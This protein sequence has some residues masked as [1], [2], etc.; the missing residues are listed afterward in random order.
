MELKVTKAYQQSTGS[1]PSRERIFSLT[2][3]LVAAFI[4]GLLI[5]LGG[6]GV[7]FAPSLEESLLGGVIAAG[8]LVATV[9]LW[10]HH[11]YALHAWALL[12]SILSLASAL[13]RDPGPHRFLYRVG[14]YGTA[15][16]LLWSAYQ[17]FSIGN[18]LTVK[19]DGP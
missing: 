18:R 8:A 4:G 5:I 17:L 12:A 13:L 16:F 7:I 3:R 11:R 6:V 14:R 19:R 10:L 15:L 2:M 1:G 9:A